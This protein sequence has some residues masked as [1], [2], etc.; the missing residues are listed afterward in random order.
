MTLPRNSGWLVRFCRLDGGKDHDL[1]DAFLW[2]GR[3]IGVE[4]RGFS[5]LGMRPDGRDLAGGEGRRSADERVNSNGDAHHEAGNDGGNQHVAGAFGQFLAACGV[6]QFFLMKQAHRDSI[7]LANSSYPERDTTGYE[8]F[9]NPL[10]GRREQGSEKAVRV[11]CYLTV[12]IRRKLRM[13][14]G[15]GRGS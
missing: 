1:V 10:R 2:H 7:H 6:V 8:D 13:E 14:C 9:W 11:R 4:A 12:A 3:A 5:V 15:H